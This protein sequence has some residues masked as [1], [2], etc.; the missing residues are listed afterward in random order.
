MDKGAHFYKC[1]FQVHSPRD[2]NWD[3]DR[4]LTLDER[5]IYAEEFI[6]KCRELE[7]HAVAI[8]DHHDFAFFPIIKRAAD[9]E[10]DNSGNPIEEQDKIIVYP[11]LELT[12]STPP[13]QAL[14]II[15]ADYPIENLN[16]ILHLFALAPSA[17]EEPTTIETTPIS[18]AIVNGFEQLYDKLN[19]IEALR[20][21]FIVLPNLSEGG[22]NTLLRAGNS[23]QYRKM[24]CVG[25][26]VDGSITQHGTGNKNIVNGLAREYGFKSVGI[27]QTSDNRKRDFSNFAKHRRGKT[28]PNS[29]A[30]AIAVNSK[31]SGTPV[32]FR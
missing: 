8:T 31:K 29:T 18:N 10:L 17:P 28:L 5:K 7:V 11:G 13:C 25:G 3:G 2:R 26:Y 9:E 23:E 22:R 30:L 21:K 4:P 32:C 15:D 6:K 16:Q 20:G 19:T 14:I 27:F 24:P 12:L 1:D